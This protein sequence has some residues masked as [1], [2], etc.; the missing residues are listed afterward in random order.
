MS[1]ATSEKRRFRRVNDYLRRVLGLDKSRSDKSPRRSAAVTTPLGL[2]TRTFRACVVARE[3][4][5]LSTAFNA[6]S[7]A[8]GEEA[9]E[10][11]GHGDDRQSVTRS[12][13]FIDIYSA[14]VPSSKTG[15]SYY[16]TSFTNS[17]RAKFNHLKNNVLVYKG[18]LAYNT[19]FVSVSVLNVVEFDWIFS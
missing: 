3:S 9:K 14:T 17:I 10:R 19:F 8:L 11:A 15:F 2:L 1:E 4:S 16:S 5:E 18:Y 6:Q 12:K 7:S 13:K